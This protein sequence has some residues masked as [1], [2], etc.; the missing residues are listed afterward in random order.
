VTPFFA[1]NWCFKIENLRLELELLPIRLHH[2]HFRSP[3]TNI[4][5][6]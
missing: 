4:V 5:M 3:S 2:Y 6:F 1:S